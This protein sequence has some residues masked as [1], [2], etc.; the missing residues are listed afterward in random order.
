[1]ATTLNAPASCELRSV[2]CFLQAEWSS[3]AEIHCQISAVYGEHCISDSAVGKWSKKLAETDVIDEGGQGWKSV[4][5]ANL[6]GWV[7]QVIREKRR[8]TIS[9]LSIELQNYNY[10][11]FSIQ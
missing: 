5:T 2:I 7:E 8:F 9:E 1:M 4:A 6:V 11:T 3:A 10:S